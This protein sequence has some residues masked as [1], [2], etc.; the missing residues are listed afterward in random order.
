[1]VAIIFPP[2]MLLAEILQAGAGN[3]IGSAFGDLADII[4]QVEDK[5]RV[6]VCIDT[7]EYIR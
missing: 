2:R 1:M 6:G 5:S 7:C 3:I 4:R